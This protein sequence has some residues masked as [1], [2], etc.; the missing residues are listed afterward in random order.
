MAIWIAPTRLRTQHVNKNMDIKVIKRIDKAIKRIDINS[1][2]ESTW[3][4]DNPNRKLSRVVEQWVAD[5]Q[6]RTEAESRVSFDQL[7]RNPSRRSS[8]A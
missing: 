5:I 8:K 2:K 4:S 1:E 3:A 7:F 6:E